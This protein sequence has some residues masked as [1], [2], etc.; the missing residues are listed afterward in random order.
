MATI[1]LCIFDICRMLNAVV[2]VKNDVLL[3]VSKWNVLNLIFSNP[4]NKSLI[5]CGKIVFC[6]MQSPQKYGKWP[7]TGA[8]SALSL[9]PTISKFCLSSYFYCCYCFLTLQ[10]RNFVNLKLE[11]L[12]VSNPSSISLKIKR[13]Y[14]SI[15]I[16]IVGNITVLVSYN[17]LDILCLWAMVSVRKSSSYRHH[18][19]YLPGLSRYVCCFTRNTLSIL[20]CSDQIIAKKNALWM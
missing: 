13:N 19:S 20:F 14:V 1:L 11:F 5:K 10:F 12:W 2:L 3:L 4:F 7:E 6:L 9:N 17:A 18:P 15:I 8:Q 16:T